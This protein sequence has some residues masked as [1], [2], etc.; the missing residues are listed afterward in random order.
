MKNCWFRFLI[1]RDSRADL[2]LICQKVTDWYFQKTIT[3]KFGTLFF[4]LSAMTRFVLQSWWVCIPIIMG[5]YSN[6]DGF[7][8]QSWWVCTQIMMGFYSNDDGFVLQSCRSLSPLIVLQRWLI[9]TQI[10][11]GFY[12]NKGEFSLLWWQICTPMMIELYSWS[13]WIKI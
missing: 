8:F 5:L 12:S 9:G 2:D 13:W 11:M 1:G 7:L 3:E 10:M 4:C 6:H